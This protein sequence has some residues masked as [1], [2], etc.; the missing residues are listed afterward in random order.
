MAAQLI[1]KHAGLFGTVPRQNFDVFNRNEQLVVIRINNLQAVMRRSADLKGFQ[2]LIPP[3][4]VVNM[5]NQIP[6]GQRGHIRNELFAALFA[7]HGTRQAIAQ[8]IGFGNNAQVWRPESLLQRQNDIRRSLGGQ[9]FLPCFGTNNRH[10]PVAQKTGDT[11]PRTGGISR[12]DGFPPGLFL[13]IQIVVDSLVNVRI[14]DGSF[15]R[16]I[17]P[18]TSLRVQNFDLAFYGRR[19]KGKKLICRTQSKVPRRP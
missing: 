1:Q 16:E 19:G 2:P 8:N 5:N 3:D 4:A 12:Q 10:A 11:I 13:F 9:S 14:R 17:L 15:R 6:F 18:R 7:A